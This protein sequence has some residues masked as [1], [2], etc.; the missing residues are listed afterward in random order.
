MVRFGVLSAVCYPEDVVAVALVLVPAVLFVFVRSVTG[1]SQEK[2]REATIPLYARRNLNRMQSIANPHLEREPTGDHHEG[3]RCMGESNQ[4]RL[5]S[6][7]AVDPSVS[8]FLCRFCSLAFELST[9][10]FLR[11]SVPLLFE[12]SISPS[13]PPRI[14]TVYHVIC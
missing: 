7:C 12:A 5:A 10:I 2:G 13:F 11:T 14:I 6:H 9:Y 1:D 3:H 4:I 8:P